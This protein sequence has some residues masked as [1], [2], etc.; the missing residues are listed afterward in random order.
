[1]AQRRTGLFASLWLFVVCALCGSGDYDQRLD[2][3]CAARAHAGGVGID[4]VTRDVTIGAS[5]DAAARAASSMAACGGAVVLRCWRH[6]VV[7]RYRRA[8]GDDRL[9][10]RWP[11]PDSAS[12]WCS[13][14][15][16]RA[17][18]GTARLGDGAVPSRRTGLPTRACF[19]PVLRRLDGLSAEL[20]GLRERV[21]TRPVV[22]PGLLDRLSPRE[23]TVLELMAE[24]MANPVIA[25]SMHLSLSSV[26][27]HATSI[28]RKLEVPDGPAVHRRVAAVVAY[29]E[30]SRRR[31]SAPKGTP[32]GQ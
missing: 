21:R 32:T 19:G 26:E 4:S 17:R 12:S 3:S 10:M 9:A 11:M 28:F 23:V 16:A 2:G 6:H 25:K 14:S 7:V 13:S 20:A 15:P 22:P 24:G 30:R 29:R 5:S 31:S 18:I 1:M 27:K 8:T